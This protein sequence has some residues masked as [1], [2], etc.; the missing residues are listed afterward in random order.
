MG[1]P[2]GFTLIVGISFDLY[3]NILILSRNWS[4]IMSFQ[5][6]GA[7]A[8]VEAVPG[9][10]QGGHQ[11]R[12]DARVN[13]APYLRPEMKCNVHTSQLN[14]SHPGGGFKW[15]TLQPLLTLGLFNESSC[16]NRQL[17][18]LLG[19]GASGGLI[20]L[21]LN[22]SRYAKVAAGRRLS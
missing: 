3:W 20:S 6:R 8:R 13:N 12:N 11:V 1:G 21:S 14:I 22:L 10:L 15:V 4:K 2:S 9:I 5:Q 7:R 18:A 16:A 19:G 17:F